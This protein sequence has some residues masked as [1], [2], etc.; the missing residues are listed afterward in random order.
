MEIINSSRSNAGDEF[1]DVTA[2]L[3]I[4]RFTGIQRVVREV[5]EAA[6]DFQLVAF[7]EEE[8]CYRQVAG[9]PKISE[10]AETPRKS[11]LRGWARSSAYLVWSLLRV[12]SYPLAATRT[13]RKLKNVLIAFYSSTLSPVQIDGFV[14]G[15][16]CSVGK[17]AIVWLL[18]I[19]KSEAHFDFLESQARNNRFQLG[20]YVYDLIPV[21]FPDLL[22]HVERRSEIESFKRY[23]GIALLATRIFCL[24]K[25][26]L[27]SLNAYAATTGE[28]MRASPEVLYP[29]IPLGD[30]VALARSN[31]ES[32]SKPRTSK[33]VLC[34]APMTKRK[35]LGTLLR[36][37][38][39]GIRRG[40]PFNL[41]MVVPIL[42]SG[43][44][45]TMGMGGILQ[46]R[47]PRKIRIHGPVSE[48]KLLEL[49]EWCD[50][51]AVPSIAEGYG[52]PI[53]EGIAARKHVVASRASSFVELAN[54][55][56]VTLVNPFGADDWLSA[57]N[58]PLKDAKRTPNFGL[59]TTTPM[60]FVAALRK[61]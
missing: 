41:R 28:R 26:T 39:L 36:A 21:D 24:S 19:P 37:F 12:L 30:F 34:I 16:V 7:D 4:A 57:L 38:Q 58:A 13:F 47:F 8:G 50:T 42:G 23:L 53:I 54:Y 20:V 2:F 14:R 35:N 27:Q 5:L 25:F 17:D 56:P 48:L 9:L 52:L 46:I 51:V 18:D 3:T 61:K 22:P 43:D 59:V 55:L 40:Q 1:I 49:F 45:W 15:P 10:R 33:N 11:R 32:S 44:F 6:S 60:Q 31:G 29:P